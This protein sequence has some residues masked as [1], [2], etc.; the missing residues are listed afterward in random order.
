[1]YLKVVRSLLKSIIGHNF[2]TVSNEKI[3]LGDILKKH[4]IQI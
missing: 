3:W 1:M 4:S 2:D